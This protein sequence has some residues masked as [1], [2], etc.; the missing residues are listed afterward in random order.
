VGFYRLP[1][2]GRDNSWCPPG[3]PAVPLCSGLLRLGAWCGSAGRQKLHRLA[4][5]L[6]NALWSLGASPLEH[7][8]DSLSAAFTNRAD[9]T[10]EQF[11]PAIRGTLR[12]LPNAAVLPSGRSGAPPPSHDRA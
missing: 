2:V 3:P 8:S 10:R 12:P 5:G 11:E 4:S 7:R 9:E 1:I 6:Q